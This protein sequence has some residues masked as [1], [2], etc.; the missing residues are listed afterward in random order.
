MYVCTFTRDIPGPILSQLV[1]YCY[2]SAVEITEDNVQALLAA[3]GQLQLP[4]VQEAS[5][6]FLQH[7]LDPSNCL[8]IAS[9][10]DTHACPPLLAAAQAVALHSFSEVTCQS[11]VARSVQECV[12]MCTVL[13]MCTQLYN[14]LFL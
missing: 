8:A 5:C 14:N 1:D 6:E 3:A 7:R 11:G 9:L 12:F 4:W 2:T 10:A 13:F